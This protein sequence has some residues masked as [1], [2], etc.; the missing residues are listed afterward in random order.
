MIK[1]YQTNQTSMKVS[2]VVSDLSGGGV[3]RAFLLAQALTK[4]TYNVEVVGFTLGKEIYA[5]P[6]DDLAV[7]SVMGGL[8]PKFFNSARQLMRHLDGD[9]ILALKPKPS[10]F[11]VGLLKKMVSRRPL[12]LDFDDWEMSWFGGEDWSYKPSPKQLYRDIF[13]PNGALKEP[14]HPFYV[15]Q[16]ERWINQADAVTIDTDFLKQRFGGTYVPNGKDTDFFNPEHYDDDDC[17][18]RY[19]LSE[20]KVLMFPGSTRPHKG[21]EDILIALDKLGDPR[22]KLVIVG[23]SPYDNYDQTLIERWGDWIIKLPRFSV[24]EMPRVLAAAHTVVVPQRDTLTAQAQFPLKL[25]DGMSMAKPVI[26]T[27]VGDMPKILGETGYVVDPSS[28]DQ[29]ADKIQDLFCHFDEAR[30][31]GKAARARCVEHYS[32]NSMAQSLSTVMAG[33]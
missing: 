5:S 1:G 7:T 25:T 4:L 26:A 23:G 31:K 2:L 21:V 16:I 14:D 9:V 11:G 32:L 20:F 33:L 29:L 24:E 10:S 3:I 19:G 13:K 28:P 6:P 17:R 12:I 22:L 15:K 30:H 18:E 27:T 8:Y